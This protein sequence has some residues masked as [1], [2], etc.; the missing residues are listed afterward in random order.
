MDGSAGAAAH[1][2]AA[3]GAVGV[4]A[5]AAGAGVRTS[6]VRT[7][8]VSFGPRFITHPQSVVAQQLLGAARS[9][10]SDAMDRI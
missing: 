3:G 1:P 6:A 2:E 5:R 10:G 9:K 8:A 7:A 4:A